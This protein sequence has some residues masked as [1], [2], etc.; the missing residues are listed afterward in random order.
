MT[1]TIAGVILAALIPAAGFAQAP[2]TPAFEV[3]SIKAAAPQTDGR[4]MVS[5]GGDDGRINYVNVTLKQAL[6]RAYEVKDY[7]IVGPSWLGSDRFDITAKFP[8]G[9]TKK[10]VPAMLQNLLAERF[11]MTMHREK[12]ELPVYALVVGKNGPK[13]KKA[14]ENAPPLFTPGSAPPPPP[15]PPSGGSSGGGGAM[16]AMM[17]TSRAGGGGGTGGASLPRGA[18][19]MSSTGHLEARGATL[20][21]FAG[22]LSNMLDRPVLDMTGIEGNYDLALDVAPEDMVGM[23]RMTQMAGMPH[24]AADNSPAPE[25]APA[26]SIFT[27]IQ[28]LG[29]KLDPRKVPTD[30][31]IVDSMEKVPT[32]N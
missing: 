3:A 30:H 8:E 16:I 25:A 21:S 27:A 14:D 31:I 18:M 32:E 20:S 13:L 23:R 17:A 26:P 2:A 19:I 7:Q 15:P 11:K 24:A 28:Q 1:K 10:D 6:T 12:R 29:L 22:M 5:M 9:A 4:V